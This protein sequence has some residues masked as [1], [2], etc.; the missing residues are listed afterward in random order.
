MSKLNKTNSKYE[1]A[2]K[3]IRKAVE[4]ALERIYSK[5]GYFD[6]KYP[7]DLVV[8]LATDYDHLFEWMGREEILK[9]ATKF[10]KSKTKE[11][12]KV[13]VPALEFPFF[14]GCRSFFVGNY[15]NL[16]IEME[17]YNSEC[18]DK[19][20]EENEEEDTRPV[21]DIRISL[22]LKNCGDSQERIL[23]RKVTE[24][25]GNRGFA[26]KVA[27]HNARL[28]V[29]DLLKSTKSL[30]YLASNLEDEPCNEKPS[31]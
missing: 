4:E 12:S 27:I 5:K 14:E 17:S 26:Q 9:M 10:L 2:K 6:E 8:A 18:V 3:E 11:V 20:V 25:F 7:N 29:A 13:K 22:I 24:V 19:C 21:W 16:E 31:Y 1:K 15:G 30:E 23:K 28:F